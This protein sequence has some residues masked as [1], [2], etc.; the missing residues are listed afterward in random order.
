[1]RA[2]INIRIETPEDMSITDLLDGIEKAV[3]DFSIKT[4]CNI[5]KVK[6]NE[7]SPTKRGNI[8][9]VEIDNTFNPG[10]KRNNVKE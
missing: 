4:K 6:V 9:M 10:K 7:L 2:S 8:A 3:I 1:M 5:E